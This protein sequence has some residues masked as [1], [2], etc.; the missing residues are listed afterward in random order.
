[1]LWLC[2]WNGSCYQLFPHCC[3]GS[4]YAGGSVLRYHGGHDCVES[5]NIKPEHAQVIWAHP[6]QVTRSIFFVVMF[7]FNLKWHCSSNFLHSSSQDLPLQPTAGP[8]PAT[9]KPLFGK[10][11][12]GEK[13]DV[14]RGLRCRCEPWYVFFNTFFS[15]LTDYSQSHYV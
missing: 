14:N 4:Y 12:Q 3:W 10:R 1:M 6:Q 9:S 11:Q 13:G 7:K 8:M 5:E 2:K 15:L